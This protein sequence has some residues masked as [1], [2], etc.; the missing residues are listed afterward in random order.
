[1]KSYVYASLAL[2]AVA[3]MAA[4]ASAS[5]NNF[6]TSTLNTVGLPGF[7]PMSDAQAM[8]VRG[9]FAAVGGVEYATAPGG[10]FAANGYLAVGSHYA[11]GTAGSI[12]ISGIAF[13][14]GHFIVA[15]SFAT[16][17]ATA[18]AH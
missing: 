2:V 7:I 17:F 14:S 13:S 12:A 8:T 9:K 4:P 6:S 16:G 3:V 1:M 11:K 15:G 5:D 10:A 18:V